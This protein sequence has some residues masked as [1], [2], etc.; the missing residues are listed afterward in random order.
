MR[1]SRSLSRLASCGVL[2]SLCVLTGCGQ[3]D[4]KLV[5]VSGT[6]T[7]AGKPIPAGMVIFEPDPAKGN[8]GQ[9]GH[10]EIKNGRFDTRSSGKGVVPGAQVVRITGGDG[11][12]PEPF[13]PYGNLLFEEHS[14]RLGVAADQPDLQ[15]TVP[16]P[17]ARKRF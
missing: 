12:N 4:S 1:T 13:T 6:V 3:T 2:I 5:H 14:V 11:V 8:R 10:A 16:G 9:Q 15:L 7:V 17:K